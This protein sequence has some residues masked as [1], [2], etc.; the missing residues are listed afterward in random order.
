M[1][2]LKVIGSRKTNNYREDSDL[3]I[4]IEY[5]CNLKEYI[6][7]N[8]LNELELEYNGL[9]IDFFPIKK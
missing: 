1:V 5:K 9:I 4:L 3:D 7:F 8:M 6:V 2:N